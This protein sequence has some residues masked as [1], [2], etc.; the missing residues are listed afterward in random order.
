MVSAGPASCRMAVT[1]R[2]SLLVKRCCVTN[3]L[4]RWSLSCR[5]GRVA[6]VGQGS[7][8]S[9]VMYWCSDGSIVAKCCCTVCRGALLLSLCGGVHVG[10]TINDGISGKPHL[11]C[12]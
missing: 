5:V 9:L 10:A 11:G 1:I 12:G 7:D 6:N 4:L 3:V 8:T 2:F